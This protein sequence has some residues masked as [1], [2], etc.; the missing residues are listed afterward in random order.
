M[1]LPVLT[2][3]CGGTPIVRPLVN[4]DM[5]RPLPSTDENVGQ[6][7]TG[8]SDLGRVSLTLGTPNLMA[9]IKSVFSTLYYR[10]F[11]PKISIITNKK[12]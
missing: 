6:L 10:Y 3:I 12:I 1:R 11:S 2:E 7:F 8:V 4:N 5:G 9:L